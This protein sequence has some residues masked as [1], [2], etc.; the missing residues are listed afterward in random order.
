MAKKPLTPIAWIDRIL[1]TAEE[2]VVYG[3]DAR[4][5]VNY[6]EDYVEL[7]KEDMSMDPAMRAQWLRGYYTAD[8]LKALIKELTHVVGASD[9]PQD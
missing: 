5:L 4:E 6:L 9:A 2:A 3:D 8:G 1:R 7:R